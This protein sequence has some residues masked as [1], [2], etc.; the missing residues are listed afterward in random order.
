ML[1]LIQL[2]IFRISEPNDFGGY[3]DCTSIRQDDGT[4]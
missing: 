4:N 2:T 3:E 1:P